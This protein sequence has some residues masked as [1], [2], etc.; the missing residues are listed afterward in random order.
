MELEI[1]VKVPLIGGRLEKLMADKV[2]EGMDAEHAV[3]VDLS[4][5]ALT[6]RR[7]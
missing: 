4:G 2:A 3:G 6:C 5:G 7:D 1:K